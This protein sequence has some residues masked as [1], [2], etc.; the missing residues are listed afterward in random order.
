MVAESCFSKLFIK[1][2][3]V[4]AISSSLRVLGPCRVKEIAY[5]F[6]SGG[7][8]APSYTL[9]RRVLR[10]SESLSSLIVLFDSRVGKV[11]VYDK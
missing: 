2:C 1:I 11:L 10:R 7:R 4:E 5:D 6:F 9:T 3:I 8:G